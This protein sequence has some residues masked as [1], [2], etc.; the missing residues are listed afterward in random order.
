MSQP[1]L[2]A[3]TQLC[4]TKQDVS[5]RNILFLLRRPLPGLQWCHTMTW[6]CCTEENTI[7][8]LI[9]WFPL[10]RSRSAAREMHFCWLLIDCLWGSAGWWILKA[11]PIFFWHK[12]PC[13]CVFLNGDWCLTSFKRL[14]S[15]EEKSECHWLSWWWNTHN[16]RWPT[17]RAGSTVSLYAFR[18]RH[19]PR[20][21]HTHTCTYRPGVKC[22]C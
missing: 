10:I 1:R 21:T 20:V 11:T 22:H 12:P 9:L 3:G 13:F 17:R 15:S 5:N 18:S 16:H 4:A 7:V 6:N 14:T 19:T 8:L 2:S